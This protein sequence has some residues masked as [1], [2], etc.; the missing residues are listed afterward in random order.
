MTKKILLAAITLFAFTAKGQKLATLK[1]SPKEYVSASFNY[2]ASINLDEITFLPASQ[3][4]LIE[5]QDDIRKEV[6]YQIEVGK[7]RTLHWQINSLDAHGSLSYDLIKKKPMEVKATM[8]L[9]EKDG[10]L[11][12]NRDGKTLLSYQY[13]TMPAPAGIDKSFERSGFI[14]P[15]NTPKGERLTRIQPKDHYHH[16]GI[17]NPWTHVLFEGDTLDF[18]NLNKKEATVRFAN[19]LRKEEGPIYADF[20]ELHEHVVLKNG[21]IALNETQNVR[22]FAGEK[23]YY[24]LDF[25]LDMSPADKSPFHIL[26]YRYGGFGWRTTEEWDNKNSHVLSSEGKT[27]KDADGSTAKWF[28]VQGKLGEGTGGAILMSHPTNFNHPEPLRIWPEDTYVRGDMFANFAPT[29][30]MDWILEPGKTSNLKYRML[31][32]DGDMTAE[33]AEAAW[34]QF[35]H[36]IKI[37]IVK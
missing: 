26:E 34:Q 14:H 6:P 19:F 17:W 29:K 5:V 21:K 33:K 24:I 31:I 22:A 30:N 4:T 1:I 8:T 28:I 2:N 11:N 25:S 16:Y 13:E 27:R 9:E 18:W 10:K 20:A 12:V 7:H 37:E 35:A 36:P 32:F 23:D 15:L 3:L